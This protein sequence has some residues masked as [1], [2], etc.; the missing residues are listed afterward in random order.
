MEVKAE[1][2]IPEERLEA[3]NLALI[4]LMADPQ[5]RLEA[6]LNSY[7]CFRLAGSFESA[8]ED[9]E[10][11]RV[12]ADGDL[13]DADLTASLDAQLVALDE[14]EQQFNLYNRALCGVLYR[15]KKWGDREGEAEAF[16]SFAR[17][18]MSLR[19]H[20]VAEEAFHLAA[21]KWLWTGNEE[22]IAAAYD[23]WR[24]SLA[25]LDLEDLRL[26][27]LFSDERRRSEERNAPAGLG[28]GL[29][30]L[31]SERLISL[32]QRAGAHL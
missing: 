29:V 31:H 26:S 30:P 28:D 13:A 12:I 24:E 16:G 27:Q 21:R 19:C 20:A 11:A 32:P 2:V 5:G 3:L 17:T 9:L 4:R 14:D 1:S 25:A 15:H 8:R 22:R 23:E 18:M 10:L 6:S 7:E